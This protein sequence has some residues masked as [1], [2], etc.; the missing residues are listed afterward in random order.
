ME[1]MGDGTYQTLLESGVVFVTPGCGPCV[2][3]HAGIPG[4]GEAVISTANRNFKGRMGNSSASIYLASP[5]TV[6]ASAICGEITD[7]REYL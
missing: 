1:A 7:P 3:T 2:G 5:A 4:D 6:A